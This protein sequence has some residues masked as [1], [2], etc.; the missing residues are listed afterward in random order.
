MKQSFFIVCF[1][2]QALFIVHSSQIRKLPERLL[3]ASQNRAGN[4]R[5]QYFNLGCLTSKLFNTE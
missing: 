4:Q 3:L 1:M 5:G 2:K